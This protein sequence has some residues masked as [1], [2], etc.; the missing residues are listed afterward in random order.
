MSRSSAYRAILLLS[1]V[2]MMPTAALAASHEGLRYYSIRIRAPLSSQLTTQGNVALKLSV[3]PAMVGNGAPGGELAATFSPRSD[4]VTV[5]LNAAAG[6]TG[7]QRVTSFAGLI[8]EGPARW[9]ARPVYEMFIERDM[10]GAT[11]LSVLLGSLYKVRENVTVDAGL[12]LS[13]GDEVGP[14]A[15]AAEVRCGLTW[16]F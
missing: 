11:E 3:L 6:L 9:L 10:Y 12:R 8:M 2:W 16:S 13:R 4:L 14:L 1:T 7:E 5:H 15:S